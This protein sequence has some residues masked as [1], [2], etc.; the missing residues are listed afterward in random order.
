MGVERSE[1]EG[2]SE[3]EKTKD[4]GSERESD[5]CNYNL[6]WMS[7]HCLYSNELMSFGQSTKTAPS[8][9]LSS[10][11]SSANEPPWRQYHNIEGSRCAR[12]NGNVP[13]CECRTSGEV[14]EHCLSCHRSLSLD[15]RPPVEVDATYKWKWSLLI[16][17]LLK[18]V[19]WICFHI[20]SLSHISD[21]FFLSF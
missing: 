9:K 8:W 13:V 14:A 6:M 18:D 3:T 20:G 11:A 12:M 2:K 19:R 15:N 5:L 4:R 21:R 16:I 7:R 10:Q 1:W 17:W